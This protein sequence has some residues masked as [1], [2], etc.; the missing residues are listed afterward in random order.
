MKI[1]FRA[2]LLPFVAVFDALMP[3]GLR[4]STTQIVP[5]ASVSGKAL[6]AVIAIMSFLACLTAGAVYMVNQSANAWFRDIASEVTVQITPVASRPMTDRLNDVSIF[7]SRQK[8]I[9]KIRPLSVADSNELLEPWLGKSSAF[10]ALPMPRLIAV[11]VDRDNPP[12]MKAL[13]KRLS[14]QFEKVILDDHRHW[15]AQIRTVTRSVALGGIV[16]LM[17]VAIATISI[18]LSAARAAMA[19]NKDIVE[20]LHFVGAKKS[21]ITN[22]FQRHFLRTGIRSGVLGAL[23]ATFAFWTMPV[24]MRLMGGQSI[25]AAELKRFVGNATLDMQGHLTLL[26]V[27]VGVSAI[28]MFTSRYWV[29]RIL[30]TSEAQTTGYVPRQKRLKNWSVSSR[31]KRRPATF[32]PGSSRG[33]NLSMKTVF[34]YAKGI[35]FV[36]AAFLIIGFGL[37]VASIEKT[38][39]LPVNAADG[40]VVLT[41]GKARV[42][43]AI[44]L[45]AAGKGRKLLISGANNKTSQSECIRFTPA[46]APLFDCCI[47]LGKDAQNTLGNAQEIAR[48]TRKRNFRSLIFV[49]SNYHMPRA[50]AEAKRLLPDVEF[51]PYSVI[52]D[53]F[54]QGT[55][56]RDPAI[57][58]LLGREYLKMFRTRLRSWLYPVSTTK[59]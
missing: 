41:G 47:E 12:D 17:L 22:E 55:W 14:R 20:V 24:L 51:K 57:L 13:G 50:L 44:K 56:W 16:L 1:F 58:M 46:S 35:I 36:A 28:C 19:A 25:T 38:Q 45:L 31:F 53:G 21:F 37:F 30:N 52:P 54:K 48:W 9:V 59:R 42:S 7:L 32:N 40:I 10:D 26:A 8:G 5:Q 2:I 18:V 6:T 23:A 4:G 29:N 3:A 33:Q 34:R 15:Q 43:E 49:T 27:V 11:E 39:K